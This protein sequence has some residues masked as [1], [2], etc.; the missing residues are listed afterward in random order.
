MIQFRSKKGVFS[1]KDLKAIKLKVK[2]KVKE[3]FL[4]LIKIHLLSKR[5]RVWVMY[6]EC[7]HL[8]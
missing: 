6:Q 8:T 3:N 5:G 4:Y 2:K 1:K 7:Q